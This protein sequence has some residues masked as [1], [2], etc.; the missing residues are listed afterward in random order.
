MRSG[1][2]TCDMYDNLFHKYHQKQMLRNGGRCR[3]E[4]FPRHGDIA[5]SVGLTFS[6][7]PALAPLNLAKQLIFC[8]GESSE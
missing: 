6:H 1:S 5:G 3:R 8:F 2:R 4:N 7:P